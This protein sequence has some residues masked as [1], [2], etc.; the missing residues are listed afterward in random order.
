MRVLVLGAT[1]L[2]GGHIAKA[3]LSSGWQ[4]RG[5]RRN[6]KITGNLGNA[7]VEWVAGNLEHPASIEAAMKDINI[8]FHAAAFAPKSDNPKLVPAQIVEARE[9]TQ[10]VIAA[11]QKQGVK[12]L[13]FTSTLST[14][15]PVPSGE[16][17][18]ADESDVYQLGTFP[19]NGYYESKIAME[20]EILQVVE[21]GLDAVILNPTAVFGPGDF[22]LSMGHVLLM[23][24]RG[25]TFAWLPGEINAIDVRDVAQAH[26]VAAQK[27]RSGER[28]ILG[29]HNLSVREALTETARIAGAKPPRFEIPLWL[30]LGLVKI[31]DAFPALNFPSNHLRA[32]PYWQAYN[33]TKAQNE[34]GLSPRPFNETVAD[35]LKWFR[36]NRYL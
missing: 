31:G 4:V 19:K 13:I 12:R 17:R 35:A 34:L 6:P 29:G 2:I 10:R 15:G 21:E 28:Y 14:I 9:Q 36:E 3:A 25:R 33:I 18:L 32:L 26:I 11:V 8:V 5:Y 27:G 30:I 1:G 20:E 7:P 23:A 16:K 24:A 22:H